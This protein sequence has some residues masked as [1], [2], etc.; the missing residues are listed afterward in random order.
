M[1]AHGALHSGLGRQ[2][3]LNQWCLLTG[4]GSLRKDLNLLAH[5][6]FPGTDP[7]PSG[8]PQ[9]VVECKGRDRKL[10]DKQVL[11]YLSSRW[12]GSLS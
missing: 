10:P 5:L 8:T 11:P 1:N 3:A 4:P 6:C 9:T 2:R 12:A 7:A